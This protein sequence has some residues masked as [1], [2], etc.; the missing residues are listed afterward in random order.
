M[1]FA[2]VE[3]DH[4]PELAA[5]YEE[6]GQQWRIELVRERMETCRHCG[7]DYDP[8]EDHECEEGEAWFKRW[9]EERKCRE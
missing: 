4:Y 5:W 8:Y 2:H 6:R 7:R 9:E 1:R 3:S